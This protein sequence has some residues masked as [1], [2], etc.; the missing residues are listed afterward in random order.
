MP[1]VTCQVCKS[2]ERLAMVG[3]A[4]RQDAPLSHDLFSDISAERRRS[5]PNFPVSAPTDKGL[6]PWSRNELS[7]AG[8]QNYYPS[9]VIRVI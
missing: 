3:L 9:K 4:L 5:T 6:G 1:R 8:F 2:F 7:Y